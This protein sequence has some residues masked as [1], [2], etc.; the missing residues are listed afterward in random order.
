ME[1]QLFKPQTFE[2][3]RDTVVGSCN[4][5]QMAERWEK[6]TPDF[7]D[8]II[9][10]LDPLDQIVLDYGC[11]VG[12]IAKALLER[13][14]DLT[15]LGVDDSPVQLGHATSYVNSASFIPFQPRE[16]N[17]RVDLAYC[18]YVLQHIPAIE[19]REA[20]QRIHTCLRP[21]GLF[22]YCSSVARMAIRF[23]T[24]GFLDDRFLGIDLEREVL[25]YFEPVDDLFPV[26]TLQR[27][28]V[29]RRMILGGTDGRHDFLPHPA[30]IY[31]RRDI[32]GPLFNAPFVP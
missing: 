25:R 14:P 2:Q 23:D 30:T 27:N 29:L 6:E 4:G 24:L 10:Q 32:T 28:P 31:R 15:L 17:R 11:G 5:F 16:L 7:A 1:H 19:V 13:R 22:I 8:A 3:G 20:L 18:V 26:E 9:A 21:G 12:R